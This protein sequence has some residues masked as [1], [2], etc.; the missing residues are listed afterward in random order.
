M[1]ER[2]LKEIAR[3]ELALMY[4]A[5]QNDVNSMN[6]IYFEMQKLTDFVLEYS[7]SYLDDKL[8]SE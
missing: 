3:L 2:E 8:I 4:C 5:K 1:Y 6:K 7:N